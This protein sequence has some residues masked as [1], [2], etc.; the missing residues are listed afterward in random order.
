MSKQRKKVVS[1]PVI[2]PNAAGIGIGAT[3]ILVAVPADRDPEPIRYF[4]TFTVDLE[5][6]A[7]WLQRCRI[8][9]VAMESTGIY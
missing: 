4:L 3:E 5:R 6:L 7:D 9:T 1:L 8:Q 2:E